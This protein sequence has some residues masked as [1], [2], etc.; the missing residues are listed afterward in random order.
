[1]GIS[2]KIKNAAGRY[3]GRGSAGN[4]GRSG[5]G[6]GMN[7]KRGGSPASSSGGIGKKLRGLLNR[8]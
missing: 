8:R 5:A 4:T 7:T 1:M 6:G 3:L 2:N